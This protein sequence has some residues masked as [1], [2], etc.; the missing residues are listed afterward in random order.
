MCHGTEQWYKTWRRIYLLLQKW[1]EESGKF[2]CK[3]PKVLKLALWWVPFVQ[4]ILMHELK[5]YRGVMYKNTEKLC[6][7]WSGINLLFEKWHKEVGEF[8]PGSP[9]TS[10]KICTLMG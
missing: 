9:E 1:Y 7:I 5:N 3:H 8:S 10:L 2:S 4:N 6:I